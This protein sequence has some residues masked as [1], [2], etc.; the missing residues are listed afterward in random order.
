VPPRLTRRLA[1]LL[2]LPPTALPVTTS[3]ASVDQ[4]TNE[5]VEK[6]LAR[7]GY[8]GYAYR[9]RPGSLSHPAEVLLSGLA[10][11]D[12]EPRLVEALPWLLL[13][14]EGLEVDRLVANAKARN[15]QNRLGFV[16]ALA[17]QVAERK[18]GFE[19]RLPELRLLEEALEPCRLARE[20]T[21]GQG[22]SSERLRGWLRRARTG[23]ARHWNLLTD[24]R[25]EHLSYAS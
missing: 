16:V 24:L 11:D 7:L 15:L 19:R 10:L 20:E 18:K 21:F 13:H 9:K 3:S 17:R 5:W 2:D 4:P 8:P 12:L 23:S 25:V 1:P 6:Q 14:Y 22:E